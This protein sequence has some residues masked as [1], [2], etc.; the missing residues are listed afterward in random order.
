LPKLLHKFRL[1]VLPVGASNLIWY[2]SRGLGF[3][4]MLRNLDKKKYC[5]LRNLVSDSHGT[6]SAPFLPHLGL[7]ESHVMGGIEVY[8][9]SRTFSI[10]SDFWFYQLVYET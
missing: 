10:S 6:K 7:I 2:Q 8:V 1:L 3:K 4:Y 5:V 9:D